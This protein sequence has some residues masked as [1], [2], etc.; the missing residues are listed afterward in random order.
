[1]FASVHQLRSAKTC[2]HELIDFWTLS[3]DTYIYM[4]IKANILGTRSVPKQEQGR[5]SSQNIELFFKYKALEKVQKPS[6]LSVIMYNCHKPL[7]L[8]C[9]NEDECESSIHRE[10]TD[11]KS[12]YVELNQLQCVMRFLNNV[13]SC[14]SIYSFICREGKRHMLC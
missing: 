1:M 12:S 11:C 4:Y 3:I 7:E 9:S 6:D 10:V 8:T 2:S 13:M 5:F 14:C